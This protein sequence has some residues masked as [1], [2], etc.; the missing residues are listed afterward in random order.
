MS[1]ASRRREGEAVIEHTSPE[2]DAQLARRRCGDTR[3]CGRR[4]AD[5]GAADLRGRL[6]RARVRGDRLR[7]CVALTLVVLGLEYS[8]SVTTFDHLAGVAIFMFAGLG[9]WG[10][11]NVGAIAMGDPPLPPLGPPLLK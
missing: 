1:D 9:A 3:R 11:L 10:F 6:E 8:G 5:P 2:P 4:P 7:L